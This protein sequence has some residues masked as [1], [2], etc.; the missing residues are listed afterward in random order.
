MNGFP[1]V[2]ISIFVAQRASYF[3]NLGSGSEGVGVDGSGNVV[4]AR[5]AG[6]E[7]LNMLGAPA[8]VSK[9]SF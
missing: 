4:V 1:S 5:G 9:D 7:P 6:D 2:A 3:Y 8:H